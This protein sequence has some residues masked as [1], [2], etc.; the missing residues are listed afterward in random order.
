MIFAI[1]LPADTLATIVFNA[2][3]KFYE[4]KEIPMQSILQCATDSAATMVGKH[5]GFIALM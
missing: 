5:R 3:E 2:L 4:E 1:S